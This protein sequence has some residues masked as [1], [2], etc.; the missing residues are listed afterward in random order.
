MPLFFLPQ[1]FKLSKM[2]YWIHFKV[3]TLSVFP[4]EIPYHD[5][6]YKCKAVW[7]ALCAVCAM[8]WIRFTCQVKCISMQCHPMELIAMCSQLS[9]WEMITM[10][11]KMLFIEW[12]FYFPFVELVTTLCHITQILLYEIFVACSLTKVQKEHSGYTAAH[13]NRYQVQL[14]EF[15]FSANFHLHTS[16][17]CYGKL[18]HCDFFSFK[19]FRGE[20]YIKSV[21]QTRRLKIRYYRMKWLTIWSSNQRSIVSNYL[22]KAFILRSC[23][24]WT[25]MVSSRFIPYIYYCSTYHKMDS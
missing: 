13:E 9:V 25:W 15:F 4:S 3:A 17:R 8:Q 24:P 6:I 23:I 20:S 10:I 1:Y 2:S 21:L 5:F 11:V 18:G 12:K 7:S 14:I 16:W 22:L 19:S